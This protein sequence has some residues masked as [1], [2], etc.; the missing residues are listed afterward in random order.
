MVFNSK[1]HKDRDTLSPHQSIRGL[2]KAVQHSQKCAT[3]RKRVS[4]S[5]GEKDAAIGKKKLTVEGKSGPQKVIGNQAQFQVH[6]R[7]NPILP[8]A[9]AAVETVHCSSFNSLNDEDEIQ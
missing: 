9:P 6:R 1:F 4:H 3:N 5:V 7:M 8:A 2:I